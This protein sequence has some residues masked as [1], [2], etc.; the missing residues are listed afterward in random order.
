[1]L[2]RVA[3]SACMS[4]IQDLGLSVAV[5]WFVLQCVVIHCSVFCSV[6]VV[7]STYVPHFKNP[8]FCVAECCGVWACVVV[9][10]SVLHY[11]AVCCS[12]LQLLWALTCLAPEIC[13]DVLRSVVVFCTVL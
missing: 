3:V 9:C 6:T 2:Q 5:R 13:L 11:F 1:M 12:V 8:F 7:L 10:C 4:R